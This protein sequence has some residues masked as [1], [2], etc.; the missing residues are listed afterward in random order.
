MPAQI[1]ARG[2]FIP[3]IQLRARNRDK[4]VQQCGDN[5]NNKNKLT[6]GDDS[7]GKG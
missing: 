7:E 4:L 3:A 1:C 6:L 2:A 5:P